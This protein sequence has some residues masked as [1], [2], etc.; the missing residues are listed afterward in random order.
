MA[1]GLFIFLACVLTSL[2][3]HRTEIKSTEMCGNVRDILQEGTDR[4]H[5]LGQLDRAP[6]SLQSVPILLSR[7][8]VVTKSS[9]IFGTTLK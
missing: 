5:L 7:C 4:A 2:P 3:H 1:L 8:S 6:R 9:S